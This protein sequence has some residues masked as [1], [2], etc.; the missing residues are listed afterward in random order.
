M[1]MDFYVCFKY[2]SNIVLAIHIAQ[3]AMPKGGDGTLRLGEPIRIN[4]CILKVQINH[5]T[6]CFYMFI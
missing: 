1:H 6:S 4:N 2:V 5:C 3:V